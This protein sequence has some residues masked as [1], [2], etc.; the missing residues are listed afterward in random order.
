MQAMVKWTEAD[1]DDLVTNEVRLENV[2]FVGPALPPFWPHLWELDAVGTVYRDTA[3][4]MVGAR[5]GRK[6]D[7]ES[8]LQTY[9]PNHSHGV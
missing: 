1:L 7:G 9:F 3:Q 4:R 2:V 5:F 8:W 6:V